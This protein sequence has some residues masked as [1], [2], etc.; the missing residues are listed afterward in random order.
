[1]IRQNFPIQLLS[2]NRSTP[3]HVR[4][5]K[6]AHA[7]FSLHLPSGSSSL[8]SQGQSEIGKHLPALALLHCSRKCQTCSLALGWILLHTYLNWWEV[9]SGRKQQ[10]SSSW[11]WKLN[12][13]MRSLVTSS[14]SYLCAAPCTMKR[15]KQCKISLRQAWITRTNCKYLRIR[16]VMHFYSNVHAGGIPTG[17]RGIHCLLPYDHMKCTQLPTPKELK[18]WFRFSHRITFPGYRGVP[19]F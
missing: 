9:Q 2:G 14:W 18:R 15:N 17:Q 3:W 19:A 10:Q 6:C 16:L 11:E 1:M 12:Y 5:E 8:S 4:N 13:C 7:L